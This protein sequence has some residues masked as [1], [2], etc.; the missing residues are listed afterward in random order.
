MTHPTESE[1]ALY[2][3]GDCGRIARFFLNRHIR[4]CGECQETVAEF[5]ML[6]LETASA[7]FPVVNWNQLAREM[8]ANINLG[9]EAGACVAPVRVNRVWEPRMAFAFASL[10]FL[11]GSAFFLSQ[12]GKPVPSPVAAAQ[13]VLESSGAGLEV[14]SGGTSITL[15]NRHGAV[16]EQTVGAQGEIRARYIDG[17]T[18]AVTINNV[19]LE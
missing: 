7:D 15:L 9:L 8:H 10:L 5:E 18:G 14:R 19:Y 6:R 17:E 2:A 11:A 3:G 1:L 12:P 13:T 4:D 16:A